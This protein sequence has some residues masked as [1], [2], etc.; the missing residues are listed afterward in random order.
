MALT[1]VDLYA[2]RDW[3]KTGPLCPLC[4]KVASSWALEVKS[5]KQTT[6]YW[7][8]ATGKTCVLPVYHG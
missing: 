1:E 3:L 7:H 6:K 2:A 5:G 4:G 8:S